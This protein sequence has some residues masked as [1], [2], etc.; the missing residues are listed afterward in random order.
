MR[1]N[2]ETLPNQGTIT[3]IK[4]GVKFRHEPRYKVVKITNANRAEYKCNEHAEAIERWLTHRGFI[5][6]GNGD[7]DE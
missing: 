6:A 2:E 4:F 1:H 5:V 3:Q 7:S